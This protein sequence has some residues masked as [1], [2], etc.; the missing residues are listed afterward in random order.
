[1]LGKDLAPQTRGHRFAERTDRAGDEHV[2]TGDLTRVP[3]ELDAGRVDALE[4]VFEEVMRELAPIR[5]ERVRLDEFC[6][7]VDEADVQRDDRFGRAEIRL[8]R[9]AQARHRR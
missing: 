5:A 4:V 1:M 7:R 6:T 2:A 9:T 8:L 3:R